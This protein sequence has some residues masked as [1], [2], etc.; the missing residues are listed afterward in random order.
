[1]K[2]NIFILILLTTSQLFAQSVLI[3]PG[4]N[5]PNIEANS[6]TNGGITPPR[7]TNSQIQTIAFPTTGTLVFDTDVNCL[8]MF[9]G[10]K[11]ECQT[12]GDGPVMTVFNQ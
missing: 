9:D 2:K 12:Q 11:W 8:R 10:T 4:I 7:M 1:M 5:S 6:S 3:T